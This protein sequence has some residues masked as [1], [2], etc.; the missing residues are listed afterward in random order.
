MKFSSILLFS[1]FLFKSFT[2]ISQCAVVPPVPNDPCYNTTI[3]NDPFCCNVAWDGLC[4]SAYNNCVASGGNGGGGGAGVG[5]NT[6]VSICTPGLAGP[7]VF[8]QSTPGPPTDYANPVGC[9]TGLFGNNFG[10]GFIILNITTSGPLNLL[11]DGNA[12][13]GFIDVVVYN[14]PNGQSPCVAVMNS[15]NEIGCNY[16]TAAV[17]CTQFGNDFGCTSS[18]PAPWVNAGDQIMIIVHDYSTASTSF[19]LNLGPTGAQTGP[20]NGTITPVGPFCTTDPAVQLM[21]ADMG[22]DWSGPGTSITGT[23]NPSAAGLGTHTINYTIGAAPCIAS[24]TTTISVVAAPI[25]GTASTPSTSVC[26]TSNIPLSLTGSSGSIQWQSAPAAGGPWTNI[27]GGTT[28]NYTVNGVAT[29]TCFR[30]MVS[31]CGAPVYSNTVCI[32]VNTPATV[33]ANVD[34]TICA[35]GTVT[36]AGAFGGG[37]TSATWS[38]PSGTFS[39]ATNMAATYT[40]TITSGTVTITLTTN[41]PAGPCPA[42]TDQMIVTVNPVATVN[43]NIDQTICAGGTVTL[44]GAFGGH[45][46]YYK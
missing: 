46:A 7:F 44:A 36:L 6:D 42:V 24:G 27:A 37:A 2:S 19:T 31:G 17:G 4:Q 29:N 20:P 35:G 41:D 30:A 5:C 40:P 23:F 25:A 11:V 3:A 21:A 14:I 32:T 1:F 18:L 39:S 33:N 8:D 28:A 13:T 15:A 45:Y 9:A 12:A 34:Q 16:A 22:G 43:A 26:G 38:A 10:F